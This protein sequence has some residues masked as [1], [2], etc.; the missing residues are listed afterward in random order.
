MQLSRCY[1]YF[2]WSWI[3]QVEVDNVFDPVRPEQ[4]F[5][6][7]ARIKFAGP[8]FP[9]A[10]SGDKGGNANLGVWAKTPGAYAFLRAFLSTERLTEL[11]KDLKV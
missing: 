7:W 2:F 9:H 3:I 8:R 1:A 5:D 4:K 6:V 10:R 11:L